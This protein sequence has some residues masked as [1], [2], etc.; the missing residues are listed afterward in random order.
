MHKH[1]SSGRFAPWAVVAVVTALQGGCK[2]QEPV[3]TPAVQP[4]PAAPAKPVPPGESF[5]LSNVR[6]RYDEQ[7]SQ[8]I[9]SYEVSN[10]G[11]KRERVYLCI[12][13][14]DKDGFFVSQG[15]AFDRLNLR[16]G[17][18]DQLVDEENYFPAT[19][20]KPTEVLRFYLDKQPC[21]VNSTDLRGAALFLD[22]SGKALPPGAQPTGK[23]SPADEGTVTG[24]WFRL[25][26]VRV[27]QNPQEEV[28]LEYKATNLTK[29]RA[30]SRLC[31]RLTNDA[32]CSCQG[33]DE[34]ESEEFN[35]G[36]G[37]SEQQVA[38][39]ALNDNMNWN[40]GRQLIIYAAR[41][42]CTDSPKEA[43][44][45]ILTLAKPPS[46]SIQEPEQPL[47]DAEGMTEEQLEEAERDSARQA[48]E[49]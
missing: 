7:R 18:S 41:F 25:D 21:R 8:L 11:D 44:S 38:R 26:G 47:E 22:K 42:G 9:A 27:F 28:M 6:F 29:G 48:E 43:T 4:Q 37:A 16:P 34:A 3:S 12:D 39:L 36:S 23:M 32:R 15:K 31:V 1:S 14:I 46:I 33:I 24:P 40:N 35:L 2:K 45:T 10:R 13:F 30:S 19:H 49:E 5:V 20:W 17:T